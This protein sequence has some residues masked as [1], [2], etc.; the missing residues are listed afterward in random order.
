MCKHRD[1]CPSYQTTQPK[2]VRL[3]KTNCGWGD[4]GWVNDGL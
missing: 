3:V 1:G 4:Q 2:D